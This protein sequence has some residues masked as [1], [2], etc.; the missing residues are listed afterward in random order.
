M[1]SLL[2]MIESNNNRNLNNWNL[3]FCRMLETLVDLY[4]VGNKCLLWKI[5]WSLTNEKER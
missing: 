2:E 5:F 3:N 4:N 1:F